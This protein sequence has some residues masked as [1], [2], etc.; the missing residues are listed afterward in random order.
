[1]QITKDTYNRFAEAINK[2]RFE[3]D[4]EEHPSAETIHLYAMG[5]LGEDAKRELADHLEYCWHCG[6]VLADAVEF[7]EISE[8][9]DSGTI[10]VEA[11]IPSFEQMKERAYG[12]SPSRLSQTLKELIQCAFGRPSAQMADSGA[13]LIDLS[14]TEDGISWRLLKVSDG[15]EVYASAPYLVGQ[16]IS[17]YIEQAN[18]EPHTFEC[19][20]VNDDSTPGMAAF[21]FIRLDDNFR[22][23]EIVSLRTEIR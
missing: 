2:A 17:I 20:F 1:M 4:K 13:R 5:V 3:S 22:L 18:K 6:E 8:G 19:R 9:I 23:D 16:V 14:F 12:R 21:G 15:I 11:T 7:K 10:Q